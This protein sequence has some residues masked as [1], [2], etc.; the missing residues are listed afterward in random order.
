[1]ARAA[2]PP[3]HALD[4]QSL[5]PYLTTPTPA[6]IRQYN[7]T[8]LGEGVFV[9]PQD[10]STRSW[11]CV[12]NGTQCDDVLIDTQSLCH[13]NSGIW[14]GQ[15]TQPDPEVVAAY[16]GDVA[17]AE[18]GTGSCC[19]VNQILATQ[20]TPSPTAQILPVEQ[21]AVRD[22]QYK[23]VQLQVPDCVNATQDD[24][25]KFPPTPTTTQLEFYNLQNT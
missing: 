25:Q 1:N 17:K 24:L 22:Q 13:T 15:T 10:N 11:P 7:F 12:L 18:A 16:G 9:Q 3:A 19:L 6:P 2:V 21:A 14:W 8:Q 5:L 4:G 23:L 20:P